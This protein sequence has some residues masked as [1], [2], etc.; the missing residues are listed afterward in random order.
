MLSVLFTPTDTTDYTTAS[1]TV[2]VNVARAT[3]TV[4]V[5]PVNITYGTAL[6]DSQLW[7]HGELHLVGGNSI[8]VDGV[9]SYTSRLPG[10]ALG[11]GN[12]Q[13]E[14]VTF[15]PTDA[16]DYTTASKTVTVN[17][18]RATPTVSVNPVNIT[19]GAA[20]ADSQLGGTASYLVGGNSV[21]VDGVFCN[22]TSATGTVFGAGYGQSANVT[23]T[24]TDTT[25]YAT[26]SKTVTVNVA[27][28]TLMVTATNQSKTYG[29]ALTPAGT[30][31]TTGVGQLVNGDTVTSVT[32]NSSGYAATA[33]VAGS[34]YAITPST[35]VGSGLGNYAITF[36][37]GTFFVLTSAPGAIAL[38]PLPNQTTGEGEAITP[39]A[40]AADAGSQPITYAA[41]GLPAGLSIDPATGMILGH[42][43]RRQRSGGR[44]RRA[45]SP[46][47]RMLRAHLV[48]TR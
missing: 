31:F 27:Q 2:T 24:P 13:I 10:T 41:T 14:N 11:A 30:E 18:A 9:F 25:D 5:N 36:V 40:V 8:S 16:T 4:S 48:T 44:P 23:F 43:H 3:P 47:S 15:T 1:K 28:K 33:S 26:A 19:Y 22:Y 34:P 7:R 20:L 6:A 39:G 12:G 21:S 37:P 46:P 17:V 29:T 32:L 42:G 45:A 38:K 35:A